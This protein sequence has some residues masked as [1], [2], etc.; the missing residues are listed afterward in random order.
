MS[1]AAAQRGPLTDRRWPTLVGRD[2]APIGA[3]I[4]PIAEQ[5]VDSAS[6]RRGDRVLDVASRTG[7]V[8]IVAA[9]RG[10]VVSAVDDLETLLEH[11]RQRACAEGLQVTFTSG[12]AVQLP[13][14]RHRSTPCR[15]VWGSCSRP[16]I[17]GRLSSSCACVGQAGRSRWPT[18]PRPV[19]SA[20]C[21]KPSA[22]AG[23]RT[24]LA[25]SHEYIEA[26]A[27]ARKRGSDPARRGHP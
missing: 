1:S 25:V 10:C 26:D 12:D 15:P 18:G 22:P 11:E 7:D 16:T 27:A 14:P 13:M 17:V 4:E 21:S 23:A 9:G 5:L 19:S 24:V 8:A 6:L 2:F 3:G 20:A